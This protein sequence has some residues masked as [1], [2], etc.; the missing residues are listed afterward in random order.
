MKLGDIYWL[1]SQDTISHPQV[2][3]EIKNSN[4]QMVVVCALTTNTKK[5]NI[6]GNVQLDFG[7]ANLAKPSIV[8]VSK[9]LEV[10]SDQLGEYV[11]TLSEQRVNE[12]LAGI[13]FVE[14]SFLNR[15]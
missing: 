3:I 15:R 4:P 9:Q 11:G 1:K 2:I 5:S 8:E 12:I 14:K 10:S 13:A 6:P 7:E